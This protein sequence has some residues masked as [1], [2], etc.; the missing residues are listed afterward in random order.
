LDTTGVPT[1]VIAYADPPP[2]GQL[3][4]SKVVAGAHGALKVPATV[5][6]AGRVNGVA[7]AHATGSKTGRTLIYG[8][9]EIAATQGGL[10]A[11]RITPGK[12][13]WR[14]LKRRGKLRVTVTVT[15]T[16]TDGGASN[17]QTTQARVHV[18]RQR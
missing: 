7:V 5:S 17:V 9:A 18:R 3:T 16:P 4:L 6:S 1:V 15:F 12:T 10:V 13:A 14:L 11:L 2:P 8:R